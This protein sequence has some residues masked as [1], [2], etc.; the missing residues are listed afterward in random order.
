MYHLANVNKNSNPGSMKQF[1]P[2]WL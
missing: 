1:L 2:H